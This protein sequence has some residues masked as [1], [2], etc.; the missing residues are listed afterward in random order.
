MRAADVIPTRF[1]SKPG[2]TPPGAARNSLPE[3]EWLKDELS[4]MVSTREMRE[5]CEQPLGN[6]PKAHDYNQEP[7]KKPSVL[8]T[9]AS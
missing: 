9:D 5:S 6:R 2:I 1:W 7:R 8:D 4:E 3:H